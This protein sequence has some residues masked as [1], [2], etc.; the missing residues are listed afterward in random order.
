[1]RFAEKHLERW[2]ERTQRPKE[3]GCL[4]AFG[5][6]GFLPA[7]G[8][9]FEVVRPPLVR[10]NQPFGCLSKGTEP[11][12][13]DVAVGEGRSIFFIGGSRGSAEC[14]EILLFLIIWSGVRGSLFGKGL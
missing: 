11:Q 9:R 14:C 13:A 1:M 12:V 3:V 10:I 5:C 6:A 7:W 4:C 2:T 8:I